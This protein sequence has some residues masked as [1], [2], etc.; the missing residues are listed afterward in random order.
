MFP[1]A[2]LFRDIVQQRSVSRGAQLNRISQSA[3]TQQVQEVERRLKIQL[4]DRSIRP[5]QPTAAGKLYSELC[6]DV[7]RRE[8]EFSA[9]LDALQAST[10]GKLRIASIYSVG[11]SEVPH[12]REEMRKRFP[13][14]EVQLE[15]GRPEAVYSAVL[16]DRVDLG[17]VSYPET[18]RD[19]VTLPWREEPMAVVLPPGHPL[20]A[21]RLLNASHLEGFSFIAFD[22]DLSIR[23]Q[24]DR[25]LREHGVAVN[26]VL[27]VDNIQSLKAF[28]MV[29]RELSILPQCTVSAEVAQGRLIAIPLAQPLIRPIGIVYRKRKTLNRAAQLFIERLTASPELPL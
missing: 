3:A 5:V 21:N 6:R 13:L 27:Q 14:I 19:L 29:G 2:K 4:L 11:L 12:Y 17:L 15:L 7:L 9:A 20:S 16:N 22:E 23:R 18:S 28:L 25:Y 8:E 1:D 26:I 10:E 24:I